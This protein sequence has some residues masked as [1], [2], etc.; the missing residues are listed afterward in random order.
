MSELSPPSVPPEASSPEPVPAPAESPAKPR[1]RIDWG[2]WITGLIVALLLGGFILKEYED[3]K[4][5]YLLQQGTVAPVFHAERYE[6]GAVSLD[7]YRGKV[8]ML[9]FW[10][11][12][13]GPCKEEMPYLA[14]VAKEYEAK[15]LVFLAASRD[16]RD[17]APQAV[18]GFLKRSGLESL[19]PNVI[20]AHDEIAFNYQTRVLPTLY[21]IDREGKIVKGIPAQISEPRLRRELDAIFGGN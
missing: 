20:Y 12:W 4:A 17:G 5:K 16:D 9:D 6:G 2:R 3:N 10:A 21:L 11:T 18:A 19:A 15:G 13:C 7:Q 14:S 8:V 1:F